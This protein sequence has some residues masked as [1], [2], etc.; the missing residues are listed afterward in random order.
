MAKSTWAIDASHSEIGFKIKHLMIT[1]VKGKFQKFEGEAV[2]ED[3]DFSKGSVSFSTEVAS[4]HTGD[5]QRDGHL[6]SPDFFDAQNF[7]KI[8]FKAT[9]YEKISGDNHRLTGDLTIRDVTKPVSLDVEFGG[10]AKDPWGNTKAGFTI[11]GSINRKDWGLTWNAVTE[12]GGVLVSED[13]KI[14]CDVQL[15]KKA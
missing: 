6:Q 12:A 15:I 4:I 7:P 8:S 11:T 5:A 10:I 1:N 9:K 3:D 14:N 2:T 13:V